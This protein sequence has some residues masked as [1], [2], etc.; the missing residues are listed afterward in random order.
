[1]GYCKLYNCELLVAKDTWKEYDG[2][3]INE[4]HTL[5]N[6]YFE[7]RGIYF[8]ISYNTIQNL[9][10]SGRHKNILLSKMIRL[11]KTNLKK[12]QSDN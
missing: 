8:N 7:D 12:P 1:M 10:T 9:G 6:K 3:L 11:T 5:I 4:I 2:L